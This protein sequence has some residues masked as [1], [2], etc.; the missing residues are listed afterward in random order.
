MTRR[1]VFF[2]RDGV[3]NHAVIKDN[4]PFPPSSVDEL[5]IYPDAITVLNGLKAAGFLLIGVTNQPDVPRKITAKETVEA[6]NKKLL[7]LLPLEE[8]LVCY[9]DDADDCLCRKPKPGLLLDAAKTHGI[10]LKKS[11]M[12]GDRWRDIEA[13]QNAGCTTIWIHQ[14][15]SEK[16]PKQPA[17]YLV[18]T[19][20]EAANIIA[21][22]QVN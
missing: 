19:L 16:E 5:I 17:D 15:Y 14:G 8:I 4:K 21:S 6:I 22:L 12:I 13:G 2:D 3:L 9:H 11:I 7:E 1:A 20:T 18:T 10:D